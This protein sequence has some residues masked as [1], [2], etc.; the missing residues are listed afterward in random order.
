MLAI[1]KL[2]IPAKP[3]IYT[4]VI[5]IAQPFR[6]KIGRLGDGN[7]ES[8]VYT[9]TGSAMGKVTNL[10]VRVSHHLTTEK[11]MYW[12]MDYLLSLETATI[13]R[14]VYVEAHLRKECQVAKGIEELAQTKIVMR[15]FGSSDCHCSSHLHYFPNLYLEQVVSLVFNVYRKIFEGSTPI[16]VC[17]DAE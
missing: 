4:L 12:H 7:F 9:Y 5:E 10:R 6:R 15:G 1:S 11:K 13:M 2:K 3:G 17:L 8:G 14:V 16:M